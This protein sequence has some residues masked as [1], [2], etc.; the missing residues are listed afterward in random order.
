MLKAHQPPEVSVRHRLHQPV[1]GEWLLIGVGGPQAAVTVG[2]LASNAGLDGVAGRVLLAELA[3]YPVHHC[4]HG[5]A[6]A[7]GSLAVVV[8]GGTG[9]T[10]RGLLESVND[11]LQ[12]HIAF[13][14][15]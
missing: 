14:A 12:G 8:T 9:P 6:V 4:R 11:I 15:F 10:Q 13:K 2:H 1:A 3:S 5:R 7:I